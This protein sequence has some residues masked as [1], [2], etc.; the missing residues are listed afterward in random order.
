MN[1]ARAHHASITLWTFVSFRAIARARLHVAL[2]RVRAHVVT[3]TRCTHPCT[4]HTAYHLRLHRCEW[5][6][7][8]WF[9]LHRSQCSPSVPWIH[10]R[11]R[12][13]V[14]SQLPIACCSQCA[15]GYMYVYSP[16]CP[17]CRYIRTIRT[18]YSL[19][20]VCQSSRHHIVHTCRRHNRVDSSN[21]Q[22]RSLPTPRRIRRVHIRWR[23]DFQHCRA[24]MRTACTRLNINMSTP[25][26]QQ[27]THDT[28]VVRVGIAQQRIAIMTG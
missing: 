14:V 13:V 23:I 2:W 11:Q 16:A 18:C 6:L 12:P 10:F 21:R 17:H 19:P 28:A 5:A 20:S 24:G 15:H 3:I 26:R 8:Q 9:G 27:H 4:T 22:S 7:P 25:V 1:G